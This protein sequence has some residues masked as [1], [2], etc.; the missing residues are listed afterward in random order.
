MKDSHSYF[1]TYIILKYNKVT[2]FETR[3]ICVFEMLTDE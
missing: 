3:I 2:I 1:K